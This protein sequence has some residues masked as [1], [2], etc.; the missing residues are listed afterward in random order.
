MLYDSN[1]QLLTAANLSIDAN[2]VNT[3][4][5]KVECRNGYFLVASTVEDLVVRAR[6]VGD[7]SWIDIE[8]TPID[9]SFYDG[10]IQDFEVRLTGGN[11]S[12]MTN[13]S[14]ILSVSAL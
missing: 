12:L 13:R 10:T 5:I 4:Q 1:S 14:F 9:L 11:V 7:A 6:P 2:S 8:T 3:F